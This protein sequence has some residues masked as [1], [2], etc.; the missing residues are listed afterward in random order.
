MLEFILRSTNV[1][2]TTVLKLR[3]T[4]TSEDLKNIKNTQ[5]NEFAGFGAVKLRSFDDDCG[6]RQVDTPSQ[7]CCAAEH[8][9]GAIGKDAFDKVS[10]GPRHPCI[11]AAKAFRHD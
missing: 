6:S 9:N 5:V 3:T 7:G 1:S 10:V 8:F 2:N 4:G 11:M